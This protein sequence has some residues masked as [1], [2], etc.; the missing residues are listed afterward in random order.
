M[1]RNLA[2][3]YIVSSVK[4]LSPE[5]LK[6]LGLRC[7]L[8]DLDNTI[9][10]RHE[11]IIDEDI[12]S[13]LRSL[14]EKYFRIYIISNNWESRVQ[15]ALNG[16]NLDGVIAP[17]GK[18]FVY[19]AKKFLDE[20]GI[21]ADSAAFIGDQVFTDLVFGKRLGLRTILVMPL[22]D[23]DLPHTRFLRI[24]EKILIRYWKKQGLVKGVD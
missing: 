17:A 23:Y 6:G 2:P 18:P 19:R 16:I 4:D 9:V 10:P 22:T 14:K 3:D 21:D 11:E 1:I 24:F 7:L 13:W 12:M 8:I 20:H 15:R 5:F